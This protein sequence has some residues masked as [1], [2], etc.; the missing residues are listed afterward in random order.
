V[1][2]FADPYFYESGYLLVPTDSTAMT[3]ADLAGKTICAGEATTHSSWIEGEF[4]D[5]TTVDQ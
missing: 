1:V 2:D 4:A 3:V 5:S